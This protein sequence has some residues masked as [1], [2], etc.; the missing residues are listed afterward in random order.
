MHLLLFMTSYNY[1]IAC[2]F[3]GVSTIYKLPHGA[4]SMEIAF[5]GYSNSGKSSVINSITNSK[6]LTKTSSIPG[7]TKC[8][9]LFT[10]QPGIQFIDFPGY[11]YSKIV[12]NQE[13]YW[14]DVICQY[15]KV[16]R[17][18]K[19]LVLITDI[20]HIVKYLDYQIIKYALNLNVPILV[21]LNKSDKLSKNTQKEKLRFIHDH[22]KR[23][24]LK[25]KYLRIEIFSS[26]K[27]YGIDTVKKI[28]N[29][30]L[31]NKN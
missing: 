27:R 6:K 16:R 26:T 25:S 31:S 5:V 13:T 19:G 29:V 30:W 14:Y 15:L 4:L 8:I 22:I 11:G 18:L 1:R 7:N 24:F 3:T 10:I 2:F 20:R 9:N 17:N 23:I 21:L 28:F 12:K